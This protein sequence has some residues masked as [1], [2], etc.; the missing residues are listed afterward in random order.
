MELTAAKQNTQGIT[1]E[2][3]QG[4]SQ[5]LPIYSDGTTALFISISRHKCMELF[6]LAHHFTGFHPSMHYSH[7]E[8]KQASFQ[9]VDGSDRTVTTG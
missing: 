6:R 2:L 7:L 4:M 1:S 9:P 3:W 8:R 5:V